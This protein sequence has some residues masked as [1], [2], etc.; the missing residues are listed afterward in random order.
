MIWQDHP[1]AA[2]EVISSLTGKSGWKPNTIR[3]LLARLVKKGALRYSERGNRYI[4][5]PCFAREEHVATA[6]ES[7]LDRVFGGAVRGLL[8]HFAERGKVTER[9][10]AELRRILHP[11]KSEN[12]DRR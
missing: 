1:V 12:D 2:S 11:P 4:Y 8:I 7:L 5:T 3:T 6:S 10:M 9:D